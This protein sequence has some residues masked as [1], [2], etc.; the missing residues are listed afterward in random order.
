MHCWYPQILDYRC[1]QVHFESA[2]WLHPRRVSMGADIMNGMH[3]HHP[4]T[5]PNSQVNLRC[6]SP[7]CHQSLSPIMIILI[8]G[9]HFLFFFC[10]STVRSTG[11]STSLRR[12]SLKVF[13]LV[14]PLFLVSVLVLASDCCHFVQAPFTLSASTFAV[15]RTHRCNHFV[16]VIASW[17]RFNWNH[18]ADNEHSRVAG[19]R[20][21][22]QRFAWLFII[23]RACVVAFF[24]TLSCFNAFFSVA[25]HYPLALLEF[26]HYFISLG[27]QK[28]FH[29]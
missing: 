6:T 29:P 7:W 18:F 14:A 9:I 3:P 17:R 25:R 12:L 16:L 19:L 27:L 5:T 28:Y 26:L 2:F 1:L 22:R 15:R 20:G 24:L 10:F 13:C 21:T 11:I 4:H 23:M 8:P